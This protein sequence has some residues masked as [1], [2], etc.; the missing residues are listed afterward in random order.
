MKRLIVV[1]LSICI[2]L[3][4]G[5]APAALKSL[6]N[7]KPE[8][9]AY[10]NVTRF[11]ESVKIKDAIVIAANL[12]ALKS[13]RLN[14]ITINEIET[15]TMLEF[16][17]ENGQSII[18]NI[19]NGLV[20]FGKSNYEYTSDDNPTQHGQVYLLSN[21]TTFEPRIMENNSY[22]NGTYADCMSF[23]QYA[24][25]GV[26]AL[27]KDIETVPYSDDITFQCVWD[28][29][30]R[31]QISPRFEVYDSGMN[32]ISFNETELSVPADAGFYYVLLNVTWGT[33]ISYSGNQYI[34]IIERE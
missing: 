7:L 11:N 4:S 17:R 3:S 20:N 21:G 2:V 6:N 5:C 14:K 29:D 28:F 23:S 15:G 9:V 8:D 33:Y 34:F 26:Q 24:P 10:L 16:V 18:V 13:I 32:R 31:K 27:L 1:F 12:T 19:G 25:E 22:S 30:N